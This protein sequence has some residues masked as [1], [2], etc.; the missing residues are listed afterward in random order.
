MGKYS[1]G[2]A[3][4]VE[5]DMFFTR[6]EINEFG[7]EVADQLSNKF[8]TRFDLSDIYMDDTTH[9][10]IEISEL[11]GGYT[12]TDYVKIDFRKIHKP[13]DINKY[14]PGVVENISKQYSDDMSIIDSA[15]DIK[16][17]FDY[18]FDPPYDWEESEPEEVEPDPDDYPVADGDV[19]VYIT[20][21]DD[22]NVEVDDMEAVDE[23]SFFA[24]SET[25]AGYIEYDDVE[26][27]ILDKIYDY[28][29][30]SHPGEFKL[31]CYL[32]VYTD[33]G[34]IYY[35]PKYEE[36]DYD[37]AWVEVDLKESEFRLNSIEKI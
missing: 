11:D 37:S 17:S 30:T 35:Y 4:D 31:N 29:D 28:I 33:V 26:K 3:Y 32:E 23:D 20:V 10:T 25:K 9:M 19:I 27:V 6:E 18:R 7:Y 12:Y 22:G 13:S 1:F 14:I 36:Y 5:D 8:N 34:G 21:S 2:G 24:N 16:S 15:T